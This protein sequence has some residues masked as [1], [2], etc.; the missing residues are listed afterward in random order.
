MKKIHYGWF[1]CLIC[2]GV[3]FCALGL[4]STAFSVYLP[5]LISEAGLTNTQGGMIPTIRP[6]ASTLVVLFSDRIYRKV[7]M[8]NSLVLSCLALATA[9]FLFSFT[10]YEFYLLAAV[11]SGFSY[12]LGGMLTISLLIRAWFDSDRGM[13]IGFCSAGS[14]LASFIVP[15]IVTA[16]IENVSL[17]AALMIPA[18]VALVIAA[19]VFLVV[20][21]NPEEKGMEPF[22]KGNS[23][24]TTTA[25]KEKEEGTLD[26][27]TWWISIVAVFLM[28]VVGYG[29]I[30]NQALLYRT[31]GQPPMTVSMLISLCGITVMIIKP[32]YGKV[33]DSLGA[34]VSNY[35]FFGLLLIGGVLSTMANTKNLVIAVCAVICLGIS[36]PIA[37]VGP[38]LYANGIGGKENH[39]NILKIYQL[40][41]PL[42]Q[43]LVG[44]LPGML[45]DRTGSYVTGYAFMTVIAVAAMVLIQLAYKRLSHEKKSTDSIARR[46][47]E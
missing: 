4:T 44:P 2:T 21:D 38:S 25:V 36:L 10:S 13:A 22:R 17:K 43:I 29:M 47:V 16:A 15:P 41:I 27:A 7:G 40:A 18:A 14:G 12:A 5:Y 6:L 32:I 42:G 37:S 33:T 45:A 24:S 3:M 20:R 11:F 19:L 23:V 9:F 34:Y 26:K 8:R 39:A 30:Q 35:L 31:S 46:E 1:V 28:G